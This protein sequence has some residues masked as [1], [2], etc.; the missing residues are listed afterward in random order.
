MA[1]QAFE[2]DD[3]TLM[4]EINMTPLVDVMLVLLIVFIVAVPAIQRA[5]KIDLPQT[6]GDRQSQTPAHVNVAVRADGS[7]FWNSEPVSE[8]TLYARLRQT[9]HD[10]PQT[11]LHL[12]ADRKVPY[13]RVA[14]VMAAAQSGGMA[15]IG[16]ITE[17][18]PE[19]QTK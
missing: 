16:F 15:K 1:M 12:E 13:E 17:P 5:I 10:N 3:D 18:K 6:G 11:E 4:N 8:Q 7:L 9:A 14:D 2:D 19:A